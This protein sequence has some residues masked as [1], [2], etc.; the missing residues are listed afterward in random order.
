MR[1]PVLLLLPYVLTG[2]LSTKKAAYSSISYHIYR[3][4]SYIYNMNIY[5][6]EYYMYVIFHR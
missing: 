3:S 2:S 5:M 1:G 4:T 6:Y